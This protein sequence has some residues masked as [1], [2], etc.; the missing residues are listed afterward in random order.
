MRILPSS[1]LFTIAIVFQ[2][3]IALRVNPS[4]HVDKISHK[5]WNAALDNDIIAKNDVLILRFSVKCLLDRWKKKKTNLL[6]TWTP[7]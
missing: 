6:T 2:E 7:K 1:F 4:D 5:A 3:F